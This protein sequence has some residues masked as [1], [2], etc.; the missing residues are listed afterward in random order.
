MADSIDERL[1]TFTLKNV[2]FVGL[3][4]LLNL[5]YMLENMFYCTQQLAPIL[6]CVSL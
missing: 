6:C 3:C 4:Y 1:H 5:L 2:L